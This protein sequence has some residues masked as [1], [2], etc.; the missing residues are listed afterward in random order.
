MQMGKYYLLDKVLFNGVI[1]RTGIITLTI[2][3]K[4]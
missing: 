3:N 4:F 2:L 1:G